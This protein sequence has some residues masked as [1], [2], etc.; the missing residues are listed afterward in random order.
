MHA[1]KVYFVR[2]SEDDNASAYYDKIISDL[3]SNYPHIEIKQEFVD[4]WNLYDCIEKFREIIQKEKENQTFINLSSGT[5]ITAI[6]GMLSCMLWDAKPY[7]AKVS[8]PISP[9]IKELPSE[10]VD[11]DPDILPVYDIIKPKNE[12]MLVISYLENNSGR[13]TKS[14]L[15][16]KLKEEEIIK[17]IGVSEDKFKGPAKHSQLRSIL[18]P[19]ENDWNYVETIGTGKRSQVVLT[20]QGRNALRIFGCQQNNK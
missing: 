6:A 17:P 9:K 19:M 20:E 13:L 8:Y 16:T 2:V 12:Y 3:K 14:E 18:K 4:V 5:K 1:D 15:I 7:Y 11:P 10:Q